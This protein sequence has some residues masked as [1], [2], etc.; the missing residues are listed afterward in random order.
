MTGDNLS[1]MD[2]FEFISAGLLF[3]ASHRVPTIVSVRKRLVGVFGEHGFLLSYSVLSL[4]MLAW[5]IA[6]AGRAPF[7]VIW[8][9]TPWHAW[10]AITA[11]AAAC[12]LVAFSI[13]TPNP[14]S[15]GGGDSQ[16]F[17]PQKPGAVGFTRHGLLWALT[18]W[19]VVHLIANGNLAHVVLFGLFALFAGSGMLMIDKRKQRQ[20]GAKRW[21]ELAYATSLWPGQSI[22]TGRW[23]PHLWPIRVDTITRVAGA[24]ALYVGALWMHESFIGV[25]PLP[26]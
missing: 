21:H 1:I 15:F 26:G 10:V 20:L 6:A 12:L 11:M 8:S 2:W 13:G 9:P 4:L 14:L 18:I 22:V 7:V 24:I 23:K 3:L 19:S 25:S 17:D 5:L 16:R